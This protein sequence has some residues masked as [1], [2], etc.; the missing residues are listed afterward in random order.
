M[1]GI[2]ALTTVRNR[3]WEQGS[4]ATSSVLAALML[5][6]LYERKD[7]DENDCAKVQG[8]NTIN[9]IGTNFHMQNVLKRFEYKTYLPIIHH[10]DSCRC[11]LKDQNPSTDDDNSSEEQEEVIQED[12]FETNYFIPPDAKH[13]GEGAFSRVF[14][15]ID[16][17]TGENVAV[18]RIHR[19]YTDLEAFRREL[20]AMQFIL[21]F[22]GHPHIISLHDWFQDED[23]YHVVVDFVSGGEMFDHLIKNG[24]YSEADAAR[25][26]R[27]VAS[28]LAFLHGIGVVHSDLKPEN[29]MLSTE[30]ASNSAIKLVDFGSA[31]IPG[32]PPLASSFTPAYA[33]PEAFGH[34]GATKPAADMWAVGVILYIMLVGLHPFALK[35]SISDEELERRIC[36]NSPPI[37]NS[38]LT[39]HLSD[40]AKELL[41]RLMERDPAKRMKADE[42]LQH[43]WV[44]GKTA[45]S[46]TIAGSDQRLSRMRAMKTKLQAKFFHNAVNWSDNDDNQR[47]KI[48]L[49]EKSFKSMNEESGENPGNDVDDDEEKSIS[50]AEFQGLLSENMKHRFFP[51]NHIIYNEGDVGDH[52]YIINSGTVEVTTSH[53]SR[54]DRSQGDFFGEGALLHSTGVRSGTIRCKTPVH[55]LEISREY[56]EKYL[57]SSELGLM[58]SVKEKDRIRKRNRAKMILS[59][60]NT[61]KFQE[62]KKEGVL[63]KE[64][65]KGDTLFIVQDGV[66]RIDVKDHH[67][68]SASKGN[69]F[70]EYCAL[71]PDRNRNCTAVCNSPRCVVK[72]MAGKDF[73]KLMDLYPDAKSSIRDLLLRRDFKKAVV[74][75]LGKEFPYDSPM[76]AFEAVGI[77]ENGELGVDAISKIMRDMDPEYTDEEI[78]EVIQMMDLTDSGTVCFDEFRKVFVADIRASASI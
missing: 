74:H 73:R 25:L 64:G 58:L 30:H 62:Y 23:Y 15:G 38:S 3:V 69:I 4:A 24:A 1:H 68:F 65:T 50:M 49:I 5:L 29:I 32:A 36:T 39:G 63:F 12:T 2:K 22:G 45:I 52:M 31:E 75:R 8:A 20:R 9:R 61:L 7:A 21:Q 28:A 60:Q 16:R 76:E 48:S 78:E 53:G 71:K 44:Q 33:P 72:L 34:V 54:A 14:L 27:E 37:R 11:E 57:A 40:S 46:D 43:P 18:K 55:V 67:V 10:L 66:I 13:L 26:L 56:F 70:G 59:H 17:N 41:E 6:A 42:M 47:R 77:D 35:S 19:E 51:K